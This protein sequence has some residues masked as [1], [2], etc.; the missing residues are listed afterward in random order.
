MKGF[1]E[2]KKIQPLKGTALQSQSKVR[3]GEIVYDEILQVNRPTERA[4]QDI[5]FTDQLISADSDGAQ[6]GIQNGVDAWEPSGFDERTKVNVV[7]SEREEEPVTLGCQRELHASEI[8]GS[9]GKLKRARLET[10]GLRLKNERQVDAA[11]LET[12]QFGRTDRHEPLSGIS[13]RPFAGQLEREI[14][15]NAWLHWPANNE[16]LFSTPVQKR[17]EEAAALLGVDLSLLSTD[18]GH[19]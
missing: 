5:T 4:D 14:S 10:I 6:I 3:F 15:E 1:P 8:H 2:P 17:W 13:I 16:L 19:A 7:C 11:D 18:A 12:T 9:L